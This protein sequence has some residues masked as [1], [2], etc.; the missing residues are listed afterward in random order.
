MS[1]SYFDWTTLHEIA[2]AIDDKKGFMKARGATAPYGGW[3]EYG[4]NVA[5][6]AQ[7]AAAHFNFSTPAALKYIKGLLEGAA[8]SRPSDK[9]AAPPGRADWNVVRQN[10]ETWVDSI[11]VGKEPWANL[12]QDLGGRI[13][14]EAYANSWVSY[15]K[16]ARSQGIKGYQFRA[17]GEWFS[18]LY[19]AYN[20]GVLKDSHPLVK[21]FLRDL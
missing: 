13:Y 15:L 14:H 17:P 16:A 11:R 6:V 8:N 9:P 1:Q 7:A 10:V 3:A 18:E 2:H 12:P 4:S 5:P 20:S 19:A 21:N